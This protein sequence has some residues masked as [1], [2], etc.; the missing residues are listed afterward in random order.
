M[1]HLN[2]PFS[3]DVMPRIA[4]AVRVSSKRPCK[5]VCVS[6]KH[7]SPFSPTL[8]RP[9]VKSAFFRFLAFVCLVSREIGHKTRA[10]PGREKSQ[11]ADRQLELAE[12]GLVLP[13]GE[14]NEKCPAKDHLRDRV[15][16]TVRAELSRRNL[17]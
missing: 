15:V 14:M 2:F 1:T 9:C 8:Y 17:P 7:F 13:G 16:S 3:L 5:H 12:L 6:T 11:G 10:S 4:L